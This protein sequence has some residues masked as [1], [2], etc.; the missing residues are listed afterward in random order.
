MKTSGGV[1]E[2]RLRGAVGK[3]GGVRHPA[4]RCVSSPRDA[5]IR[6]KVGAEGREA[7]EDVDGIAPS[8]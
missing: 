7:L 1:G 3:G 8:W 4:T 2:N 6:V 5:W